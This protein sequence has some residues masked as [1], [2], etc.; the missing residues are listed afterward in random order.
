MAG[1]SKRR[2]FT[3][4]EVV[5]VIVILAMLMAIL[6]PAISSAREAARRNTC[7]QNQHEVGAALLSYERRKGRFPGY[8]NRVRTKRVGWV[9]TIL[10]ELGRGD[11]YEHIASSDL[12]TSRPMTILVCPSDPPT[13]PSAANLS[14]AVNCGLPDGLIDEAA[15]H[16]ANA[17]MPADWSA[18]G[19]FHDH[20]TE[21]TAKSHVDIGFVSSHDGTGTTLLLG[22]NVAADNWLGADWMY[23]RNVAN[24]GENQ[25]EFLGGLLW[26]CLAPEQVPPQSRINGLTAPGADLESS[27]RQTQL[28]HR[29]DPATHPPARSFAR[30]SSRHPGGAAVTFV[31]GHVA[32][33]SEETDYQ[34]YALVCTPHGA[35]VRQPGVPPGSSAHPI[36]VAYYAPLNEAALPD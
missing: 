4:V 2:A 19:V 9:V 35:G 29:A 12:L 23:G 11:I 20:Y 31:D 10:P 3:L 1:V 15:G 26:C 18:N 8:I 13:N 16:V 27:L 14:Y 17:M 28:A 22:E 36:D 25:G 33:M 5:V 30:P 21:G 32:F 34:V 6:L 7:I 24:A